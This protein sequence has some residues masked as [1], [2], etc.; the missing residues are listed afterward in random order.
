MAQQ[1]NSNYEQFFLV[2][3][4]KV[5]ESFRTIY[6]NTA[7]IQAQLDRLYDILV[8]GNGTTTDLATIQSTIDS[9]FLQ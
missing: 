7:N 9:E 6:D 8:N 5:R 1:R 2:E 4:A 3:D